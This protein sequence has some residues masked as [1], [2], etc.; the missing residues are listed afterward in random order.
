VPAGQGGQDAIFMHPPDCYDANRVE[1][2][3]GTAVT[4]I[5]RVPRGG[6]V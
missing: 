3:L 5:D 2:L 1:L 4:G 6:A